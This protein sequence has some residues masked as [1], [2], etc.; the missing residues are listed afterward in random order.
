MSVIKNIYKPRYKI[1]FQ[2]KSKVWPYKNSRLRRFFNIRGRKLVR[3]GFFKRV[4]LVFNNMKWT[5][6][7]R[8]IRP[9]MKKRRPLRRRFRN[10]FYTKQQLRAFYGKE[11]EEVFRNFFKRFLGGAKNRN[12]MF[13]TALERRADVFLFRLRFLPTIYACRQFVHH[14]GLKINDRKEISPSAQILPGDIVEFEK[15]QW[16]AFGSYMAKRIFWRIYG[17]RLWKRRQ[18]K[19]LFKKLFYL[20]FKSKKFNFKK[21][22]FAHHKILISRK[23]IITGILKNISINKRNYIKLLKRTMK[24]MRGMYPDFVG[25]SDIQKKDFR[26]IALLL[27]LI[28]ENFYKTKLGYSTLVQQIKHL[29]K[30][31]KEYKTFKGKKAIVKSIMIKQWEYQAQKM[32]SL[33][34][35]NLRNFAIK[36]D[37]LKHNILVRNRINLLM[38]SIK[39]A[40]NKWYHLNKERKL[41]LLSLKIIDTNIKKQASLVEQ[42]YVNYN[43]K[44][45]SLQWILKGKGF[46]ISEN[47]NLIEGFRKEIENFKGLYDKS[48]Q[49]F[50]DLKK[51]F[52]LQKELLKNN[53]LNLLKTKYYYAC[54]IKNTVSNYKNWISVTYD[55]YLKFHDINVQYGRIVKNGILTPIKVYTLEQFIEIQTAKIKCLVQEGEISYNK[56]IKISNEIHNNVANRMNLALKLFIDGIRKNRRNLWKMNKLQNRKTNQYR[57]S[58]IIYFLMRRRLKSKRYNS[59]RRFRNVHWYIPAYIYF[60]FRTLRAVYLYNPKP[61]EI[62][63]SFKCSLRQIHSFYRSLGI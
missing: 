5:I 60:D 21:S 54:F 24:M 11:K 2:A 61:E 20:K 48:S 23:K 62:M 33:F 18:S 34:N 1:A 46:L 8:Y 14:F 15:Y 13:V 36:F 42:S 12:N 28:K 16:K 63:Y 19:D 58:P 27:K 29:N 26:E 17:L 4:V 56:K 30:F 53:T 38:K 59:V 44:K 37:L 32:C 7:R 41:I 31:E 3:R 57:Q 40:Y 51:E 35:R 6:A 22:I 9:Y 39:V 43:N 47:I 25:L 55:E 10:V 45:T 49:I 50:L 52:Y